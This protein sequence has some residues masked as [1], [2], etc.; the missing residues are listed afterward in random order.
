[1]SK[2]AYVKIPR[3]L[4]KKFLERYGLALAADPP[5]RQVVE[6]IKPQLKTV[7]ERRAERLGLPWVKGGPC[8]GGVT[9]PGYKMKDLLT[10]KNHA[11]EMAQ[12]LDDIKG[13]MFSTQAFH[14]AIS[15]LLTRARWYADEDEG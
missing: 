14:H 5:I 11:A 6:Y 3:E 7:E 4:A 1:M 2:D 10:L 12:M 15:G 8:K 9:N 13:T